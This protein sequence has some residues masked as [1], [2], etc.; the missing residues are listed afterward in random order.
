MKISMHENSDAMA[1][2]TAETAARILRETIARKG[3]ATFIAPTWG[4]QS[5]RP[6]V[7]RLDP[8]ETS[9]L[10]SLS[11]PRVGQ[12]AVGFNTVRTIALPIGMSWRCEQGNRER[13][14]SIEE[15][16]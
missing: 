8:A 5:G 6:D 15:Q 1:K 3:Q 16:T 12:P 13:G 10:L 9:E 7:T 14:E 2:A 4:S 11:G